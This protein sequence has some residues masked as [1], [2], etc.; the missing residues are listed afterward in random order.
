MNDVLKDIVSATRTRLREKKLNPTELRRAASE[1][2]GR[3]RFAE[4]LRN[5]SSPRIIA[6]IKA[7][8]PSAGI[9]RAE[10]D[11]A[12]IAA[13]YASGGAAAISVVTEPEFFAGSLDWIRVASAASKLPVLR[14]DF[15]VEAAQIY[16]SAVAG[17]DAVLLITAILRPQ[18][19]KELMR[20]AEEVRIDAV[21]EVHDERELTVALEAGAKIIGV[22]NR[23]LRDFSVDLGTSERLGALM[24]STV[25]RIT[26]SGL[27]TH[28]EIERLERAGFDAFL[29]GESILRQ[30]DLAAAVSHLRG[31]VQV[32]ICGITRVE[33]A[34]AATA[35]GASF[36]GLVFAPESPRRVDVTTAKAI[37]DRVGAGPRF[38][39]VFRDQSVN[40]VLRIADST[41]VHYVQLHGQ[42]T[43]EQVARMRLPVIKAL[44]VDTAVPDVSSFSA[45]DW[46]MF[47]ASSPGGGQRFEWHLLDGY[48]RDKKFFLAGGLNSENVAAAIEQVNPDAID[49][50]SGVEDSP[51][52]KSI[53]K[54]SALFTAV[55]HAVRGTPHP[56][57]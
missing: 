37:M 5:H 51:G 1:R 21:V 35:A 8:S 27:R 43:P 56:S 47:D 17:A 25:L 41:G 46:L 50:S 16:E 24:P 42:E 29:I 31:D 2:P 57:R 53:R 30:D 54:L 44:P 28:R 19:L 18:E 34:L 9:I 7:A 14:K 4:T 3:S 45:A 32:K 38:V 6:E 20:A 23:N 52:I 12:A 48:S 15:V 10:L 13:S 36:L 55:H 49:V 11:P 40:D 22:N 39:G 26:E 33:D